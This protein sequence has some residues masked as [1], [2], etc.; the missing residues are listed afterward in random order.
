MERALSNS[1]SEIFN[2]QALWHCPNL[3]AS[4]NSAISYFWWQNSR[5]AALKKNFKIVL[6]CEKGLQERG[7]SKQQIVLSLEQGKIP[8]ISLPLCKATTP[9]VPSNDNMPNDAWRNS[10]GAENSC[11]VQRED[12]ALINWK[13]TRKKK[14]EWMGGRRQ[15]FFNCLPARVLVLKKHLTITGKMKAV[16]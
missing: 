2:M 8:L 10:A 3:E 1:L 11:L 14:K 12:T 5:E 4:T 13:K 15:R 7:V 16:K 9:T 6:P